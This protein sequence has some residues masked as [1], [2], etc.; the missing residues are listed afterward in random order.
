MARPNKQG[1][2]YFS[3]DVDFF[4]NEKIEAISGE[5]GTKGEIIA[6]RLLCAIYRKGYF[7]VWSEM[8]KMKLLKN[9]KGISKD[10]L[11]AVVLRLV[12]WEF[13]NENL[14]NSANVLTSQSIQMR[15]KEATKRRKIVDYSQYWLLEK[16]NININPQAPEVNVNI[17]PQSKVK[18][19]KVKKSKEIGKKEF[20]PTPPKNKNLDFKNLNIE[21]RAQDFKKEIWEEVKD[22]EWAND[23][24]ELRK[25]WE[26]WSEHGKRDRKMRYEKEKSFCIK[27]RLRTWFDNAEKWNTNGT[28]KNTN[29]YTYTQV[30]DAVTSKSKTFDDFEKYKKKDGIWYWKLK[31]HDL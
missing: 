4:E 8:L 10:L 3:F 5:F 11:E 26:H 17:N 15:F 30:C 12:K 23:K 7:I 22:T 31:T 24:A 14:F 28:Y 25:F 29:I 20:L 6:I 27:K 16:V 1:L 13:F 9:V 21:Q 18:E 2:D 19:S